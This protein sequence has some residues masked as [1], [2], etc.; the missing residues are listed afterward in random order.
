MIAEFLFLH[1]EQ[2]E[3]ISL[4]FLP[5]IIIILVKAET[6][7]D[8]RSIVHDLNTRVGIIFATVFRRNLHHDIPQLRR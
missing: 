3:S 5:Q 6:L 4:N 1:P 2:L 7:S 8:A